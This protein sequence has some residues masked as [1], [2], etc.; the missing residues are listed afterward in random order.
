MV[1]KKK[2]NLTD[3]QR[4]EI[5]DFFI[6]Y[7]KVETTIYSIIFEYCYI[8]E[9]QYTIAC[10]ADKFDTYDKAIYRLINL[11]NAKIDNYLK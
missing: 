3:K 1:K 11:L 6:K 9:K 8:D 7:D 10:I 2:H 5:K 4:K